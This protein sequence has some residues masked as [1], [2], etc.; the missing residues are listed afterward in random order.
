MFMNN[1]R[2]KQLTFGELTAAAY[3]SWGDAEAG[4]KLRLAIE[5][6]L[7]VFHRDPQFLIPGRKGGRHE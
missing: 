2:K 5:A 7:V 3:R 6:G 4:Q 1:K